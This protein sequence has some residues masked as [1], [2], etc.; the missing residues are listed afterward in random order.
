MEAQPRR[1][2]GRW[3]ASLSNFSASVID[4]L[5]RAAFKV[6]PPSCLVGEFWAVLSDEQMSNWLGVEHQP[7][8]FQNV[9]WWISKFTPDIKEPD[10]IF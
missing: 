3:Q 5:R 1:V 4:V 2:L 6:E 9:G 10:A 8:I 7:V